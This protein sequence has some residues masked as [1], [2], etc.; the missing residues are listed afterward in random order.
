MWKRTSIVQI[1]CALLIL[2]F[3]Y[4]SV[5]K[6]VDYRNFYGQINSQPFADWMTPYLAIGLPTIEI[7]IAVA[8]MADRTRLVG[9]YA[10]MGLMVVFTLYVG[11]MTFGAFERVPC[12]C[13]GILRRL[14]WR[15]HFYF[16]LFYLL[17]AIAGVYIQKGAIHNATKHAP[18][19]AHL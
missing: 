16:N 15:Q 3:V 17:V 1:I 13:G 10:A 8:L 4:A 14:G 19:P 6:I 7:A 5:S 18:K 2:L 11:L 12:S 9:L